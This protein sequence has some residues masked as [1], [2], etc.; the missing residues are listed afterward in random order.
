VTRT[1]DAGHDTSYKVSSN[2]EDDTRYY[3]RVEATDTDTLTTYSD[4]LS[5]VVGTITGLSNNGDLPNEFKLYNP[6]PSPFNPQTTIK[7]DLPEASEVIIRVYNILGQMIQTLV[8]GKQS[9]GTHTIRFKGGNLPSGQYI[10]RMQA[11]SGFV[12]EKSV[13]LFK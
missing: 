9:A 10:I 2:L 11:G 4:T 5:F 12:T 3:W 8:V 6:Y 1:I 7:Y 13:V